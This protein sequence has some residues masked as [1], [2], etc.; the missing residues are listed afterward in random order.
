MAPSP[1]NAISALHQKESIIHNPILGWLIFSSVLF[2]TFIGFFYAS[3]QIEVDA[4]TK[5][6]TY[7]R[8][9]QNTITQHL[10]IYEQALTSGALLAS[11]S[12]ELTHQ[13]WSI[14]A[15]TLNLDTKL[16]G[17]ETL[18]W[19]QSIPQQELNSH[20]DHMRINGDKRYAIN[21]PGARSYYTSITLIEPLNW[22]SRHFIGLD[23]W[24][25]PEYREAMKNAA[26]TSRVSAT[27]KVVLA[28]SAPLISQPDEPARA[29]QKT[30]STFVSFYP[31]FNAGAKGTAT[32]NGAIENHIKGWVF[33]NIHL[34]SWLDLK[35][36][37]HRDITLKVYTDTEANQYNLLY[38]SPPSPR[39]LKDGEQL[40]KTNITIVVQGQP[41]LLAFTAPT[42]A[43]HSTITSRHPSFILFSG[44][45]INLLILFVMYSLYNF[46]K[47]R[48]KVALQIQTE[49]EQNQANLQ[50]QTKI[51]EAAEKES[52]IFFELAPEAFLVVNR[53]GQ[54]V[55]ANRHAHNLFGYDQGSLR[56]ENIEDLIPE[57][58]RARHVQLRNSFQNNPE[59]RNMANYNTNIKGRKKDTSTFNAAINLAPIEHLGVTHMVAVVTDISKQKD[60]EASLE[61][62]K[63]EA[64]NVSRSKSE[65]VAN[66]SHEI[67]TPLNAVLGAA[68]LLDKTTPTS[69]QKKYI[70]MIRSSGE[71][72][73]G[74]INDILDF[75][76]IEAGAMELTHA[77]FD[78]HEVLSRVGIMMSVNSGEKTMD[79]VIHPKKGVKRYFTGD[80]LRLQQVLI[81][82]SSNA[83]KFTQHG[84]VVIEVDLINNDKDQQLLKFQVKDTGIGMSEEQQSRLFSAFA[85]ADASISRQFGGTGLG[86][87]ISSRIIELMH[88]SIELSSRPDHGSEFYFT[89][90]LPVAETQ[91]ELPQFIDQ[92]TQHILILEKNPSTEAALLDIFDQWGW[93]TYSYSSWAAA[94]HDLTQSNTIN[95]LN[96]TLIGS[97]FSSEGGDDV[98]TRLK[99]IGLLEQCGNI[100]LL[101]NNQ[102]AAL[103]MPTMQKAFH[104]GLVKPVLPSNLLDALQEA[105]FEATEQGI[106]STTKKT[107]DN[108]TKLNNLKILLVEDNVFNQTIARGMLEDMGA[109]LEIANNGAE[110]V[111]VIKE[112]P[113]SF[114]AILMDI[115]MPVMDGVTATKILREQMEFSRPIIAMTAGVLKS[116]KEQYLTCG[117]N[118]LVPKPV[119]ENDLFRAIRRATQHDAPDN[120]NLHTVA[121]VITPQAGTPNIEDAPYF[122]KNQLDAISKGSPRRIKRMISALE[123]IMNDGEEIIQK[124]QSALE[125]EDIPRAKLVLTN[126]KGVISNYGGV[127]LAQALSEAE[128]R[129]NTATPSFNKD[130]MHTYY[131]NYC[132]AAK[133]WIQDQS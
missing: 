94:L 24:A 79:L 71:A 1:K 123:T 49:Y 23:L 113:D 72:L 15:K 83:I 18:G 28:G 8:A 120:S 93:A 31:I 106:V 50:M 75:S 17:I 77:T 35:M 121:D 32:G 81:N 122:D 80:P 73:L 26:E 21:P 97:D 105:S 33:A 12:D 78:L 36:M 3:K 37:V 6:N 100:L 62:A 5:L 98:L 88:S 60:I 30:P 29:P 22:Q 91:S 127:Q 95:I 87:V 14:L 38:E 61:K 67:R 131:K 39:T 40:L 74:I 4:Q 47:H 19:I 90:N 109:R 82:L 85:Q 96:F 25:D 70:A 99:S 69:N 2:F 68:Q 126:F 119:D 118:D 27:Q 129:L 16:K 45:L 56:G 11:I 43:F 112:S 124:A 64:E 117:M 51:I 133:A 42:W 34:P 102:Q 128:A 115:Q 86:L 110:A 65:F 54:I 114:D 76:K 111:A 41:W 52:E 58:H 66:M 125:S 7:A 48:K 20:V 63:E 53:H 10:A 55:K 92:K 130:E 9:T 89:L 103:M 46:N 107:K 101:A 108:G 132:T 84:E 59:P 116:E 57:Q 13:D 104:A 44:L